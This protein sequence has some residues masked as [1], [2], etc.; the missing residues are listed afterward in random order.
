MDWTKNQY[1]QTPNEVV[2]ALTKT[3]CLQKT[4]IHS[5]CRVVIPQLVGLDNFK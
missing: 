5:Q 1:H 4:I 3:G 2:W